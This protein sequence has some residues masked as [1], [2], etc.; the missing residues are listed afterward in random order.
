[1]DYLSKGGRP[2]PFADLMRFSL[3]QFQAG[4]VSLHYAQSWAMVHFFLH[5]PASQRELLQRYFDRLRQG[6]DASQ[7]FK[8]T[9]GATDI[10]RV[11]LEWRRYLNSL[12]RN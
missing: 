10:S 8:S 5:G 9:F 1:M 12:R 7:A 3:R 11:E 2:M 4:N 6:A